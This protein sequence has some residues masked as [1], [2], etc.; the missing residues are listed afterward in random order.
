M[1][2]CHNLHNYVPNSNSIIQLGD[3]SVI[4]IEGYGTVHANIVIDGQTSEVELCNVALAPS[5]AK[6]LVLP[7]RL[8]EL[9]CHLILNHTKCAI[10]STHVRQ[11]VPLI[12]TL[13]FKTCWL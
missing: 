4:Q 13:L 6:N 1:C 10:E 8:A 9:G 7:S 11:P 2:D 3:N 12:P 5:L